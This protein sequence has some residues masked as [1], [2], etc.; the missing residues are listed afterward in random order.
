[1]ELATNEE[2][3]EI[4]LHDDL[5]SLELSFHE[6]DHE[7]Y[8]GPC[9]WCEDVY[10]H[11]QADCSPDGLIPLIIEVIELPVEETQQF[12]NLRGIFSSLCYSWDPFDLNN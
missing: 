2:V 8:E 10:E 1:M 12:E 7:G 3:I 6:V 5:T 11:G 9:M 4:L